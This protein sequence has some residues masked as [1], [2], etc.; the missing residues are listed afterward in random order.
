[1]IFS[2][3][4]S[5]FPDFTSHIS[6]GSFFHFQ[7]PSL[8]HS[9]HRSI[10]FLRVNFPYLSSIFP[11]SLHFPFNLFFLSHLFPFFLFHIPSLP[12]SPSSSFSFTH[13][14][15]FYYFLLFWPVL[16]ISLPCFIHFIHRPFFQF[17][18]SAFLLFIFLHPSLF[19]LSFIYIFPYFIPPFPFVCV[20]FLSSI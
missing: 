13:I 7:F 8:F 10:L 20:W 17:P 9:F 4:S 6:F 1:M 2:H 12:F 18:S 5:Y 11:L 19:P 14:L 3:H 15:P 16:F